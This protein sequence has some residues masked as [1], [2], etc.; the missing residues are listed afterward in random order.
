MSRIVRGKSTILSR[1][2]KPISESY[3]IGEAVSGVTAVVP[4]K[5]KEEQGRVVY[6]RKAD[7]REDPF[8]KRA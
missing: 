2:S 3:K 7:Y 4:S 5:G 1:G 6:K 8:R